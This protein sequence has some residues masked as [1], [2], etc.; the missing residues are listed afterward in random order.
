MEVVLHFTYILKL[1]GQSLV[2]TS[3]KTGHINNTNMIVH[4][5][6]YGPIRSRCSLKADFFFLVVLEEQNHN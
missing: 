6:Y 5:K 3:F 4:K 2:A 1:K